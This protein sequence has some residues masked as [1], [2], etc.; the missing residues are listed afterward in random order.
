LGDFKD[1]DSCLILS[2]IHVE[3]PKRPENLAAPLE[4]QLKH[5]N[6]ECC[7]MAREAQHL[8]AEE[9]GEIV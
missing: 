3:H 1:Y 7:F 2:V 4:A 9:F 8:F 6:V 5:H